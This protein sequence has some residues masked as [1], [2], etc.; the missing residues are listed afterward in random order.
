MKKIT[1]YTLSLAALISMSCAKEAAPE[2]TYGD[3]VIFQA[4]LG[5]V[6]AKAVLT[7][8]ATSSKVTWEAGDKVSLWAE[9]LMYEYKADNSGS[10]STLSPVKGGSLAD[11]YYAL[12]PYDAEATLA[13]GVITTTLPAVQ[14]AKMTS[15]SHHLAVSYSTSLSL[16]FKNVCG[17]FRIDITEPTITKVE[18]KGNANEDVAGKIAITVGDAPAWSAVS[19]AKTVTLS[20]EEGKNLHLG[21]YYL[22]VLPQEFNSGV[23]VTTYYKDGSTFVK[24][25]TDKVVLAASGLVGGSTGKWQVETLATGMGNNTQDLAFAPDGNIWY[26][27]RTG[28][29][30]AHG[31]YKF[32]ISDNTYTALALGE[33]NSTISGTYPWGVGFDQNGLLYFAGKGKNKVYTCNS[34]GVVTEFVIKNADGTTATTPNTMKVI[35]DGNGNVYVLLR[36]SGNGLGKVHKVTAADGK[37]AQTW[38]LTNMLYEFMC[39]SYDKTKLFVFPNSSGDIQMIDLVS[40][41]IK[42]V[43]GTGTQ[44]TAVGAYKDGTPGDPMTATLAICEGAVCDARGTIYFTDQAKAFTIRMFYPDENGDYTKGTIKTIVGTAYTA[45]TTD[46]VGLAAKL[47]SP[48]GLALGPDGKT[49]YLLDYGTMRKITFVK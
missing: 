28:G 34:S 15:F 24:N 19:G 35:P 37:I 4:T 32:N 49:L 25:V 29:N 41:T 1:L 12:Y 9:N 39:M 36:G 33:S 7:E 48:T 38:N 2:A 6:D 40:G 47:K 11:E 27:V 46:G 13:S 45:G 23:T 3:S 43:A 8:G 18:F 21:V 22:A 30:T 44:H 17:L 14:T 42:K 31:I 26:S 20:A 5:E 10:K 16:G